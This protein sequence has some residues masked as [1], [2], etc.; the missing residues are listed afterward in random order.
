MLYRITEMD[1]Y[2]AAQKNKDH[3]E[4]CSRLVDCIFDIA[5]EAYKH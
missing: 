5:D 2:Q 3:T 1:G 4:L